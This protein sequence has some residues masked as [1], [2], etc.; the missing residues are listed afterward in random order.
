MCI[1]VADADKLVDAKVT[2]KVAARTPDAQVLR[3]GKESAHEILREAD[4]VRNRALGA[5]DAFFA[6]RAPVRL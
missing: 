3:F 4:P 1:V 5:I 6:E 2:V